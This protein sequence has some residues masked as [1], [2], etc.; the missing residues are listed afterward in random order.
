MRNFDPMRNAE[1]E[2]GK[3]EPAEAET[4]DVTTVSRQLLESAVRRLP[5]AVCKS[6]SGRDSNPRYRL[7]PYAGLANRCLQPLGH[8]SHA[9][10]TTS[11][12]RNVTAC[13]V[14]VSLAAIRSLRTE[15]TGFE[16]VSGFRRASFQDWCNSH[17]A[18]PP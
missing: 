4:G 10:L 5:S 6:R 16:P 9:Q 2:C 17:S 15:G 7:T 14:E 18:S 13:R 12:L 1:E 8:R 11:S 3:R